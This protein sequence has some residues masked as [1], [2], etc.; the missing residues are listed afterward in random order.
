M[1]TLLRILLFF[2]GLA[3][4]VIA[5]SILIKG[6]EATAFQSE[7]LYDWAMR[8]PRSLSETW[9]ATMDNELRFYAALLAAYGATLIWVSATLEAR[10]HW[11]P[12]LAGVFFLGGLGRAASIAGVG[13]PHPV[14]EALMAIELI[15]PV[16]VIACWLVV[17]L[18]KLRSPA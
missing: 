3:C 4:A 2:G 8:A 12:I 14:F 7:M 11:T 1:A 18:P 10:L 6:A 17:A 5:S 16:V 9:P 15:L 13:R